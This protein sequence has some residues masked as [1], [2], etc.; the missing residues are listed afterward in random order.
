MNNFFGLASLPEILVT[1]A[2]SEK[3][4]DRNFTQKWSLLVGLWLEGGKIE[5][6]KEK[7]GLVFKMS[8]NAQIVAE[9]HFFV[10]YMM[11]NGE[12]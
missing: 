11:K 10:V 5:L 2:R 12:E 9:N 7:M 1:I 3:V 6:K 8:K 4:R